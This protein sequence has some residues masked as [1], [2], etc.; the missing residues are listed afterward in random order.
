M[1]R[2]LEAAQSMQGAPAIRFRNLQRRAKKRALAIPYM[3]D[4]DKK[5][6]LH[7]DLINV[8]THTMEYLEQAKILSVTGVA[9]LQ[10]QA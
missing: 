5:A 2:L 3:R 7:R 4:K 1:V 6:A 8:T 10:Y 9:T